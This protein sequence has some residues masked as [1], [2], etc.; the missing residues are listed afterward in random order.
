MQETFIVEHKDLSNQ[1][2][3]V[4]FTQNYTPPYGPTPNNIMALYAQ[5]QCKENRGDVAILWTLMAE[6]ASQELPGH[7]S[8]LKGMQ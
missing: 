7:Q 2:E 5:S 3:A 4:S 8:C 6:A 1:K